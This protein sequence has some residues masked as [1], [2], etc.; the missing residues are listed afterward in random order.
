MQKL[1]KIIIGDL[2][3][4]GESRKTSLRKYYLKLNPERLA[5]RRKELSRQ[6]E[7]HVQ[8]AWDMTKH[9]VPEK[10]EADLYECHTRWRCEKK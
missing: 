2:T 5:G 3:K 1:G 4:T 10:L 7:A 8:R 9:G 6:R